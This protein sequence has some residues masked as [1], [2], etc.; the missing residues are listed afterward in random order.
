M[1]DRKG[2]CW[3]ALDGN[4]GVFLFLLPGG[5]DK[6]QGLCVVGKQLSYINISPQP[7]A[8]YH[9][10]CFSCIFFLKKIWWLFICVWLYE[11]PCTMCA[12]AIIGQKSL[13]ELKAIVS[14]LVGVGN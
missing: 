3:L 10:A 12:G 14:H 4:T 8:R 6:T 7:R 9:W 13:L 2:Y 1:S 5:E 11:F